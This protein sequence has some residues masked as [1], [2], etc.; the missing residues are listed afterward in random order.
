MISALRP[1]GHRKSADVLHCQP[2]RP[3]LPLQLGHG[4]LHRHL[5]LDWFHLDREREPKCKMGCLCVCMSL[6][7]RVFAV[8]KLTPACSRRSSTTLSTKSACELLAPQRCGT[9]LTRPSVVHWDT[10]S[11]PKSR[12]P[13]CV[14]R[15]LV[16]VFGPT[17]SVVCLPTSSFPICEW[18]SCPRSVWDV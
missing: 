16:S 17:R 1:S 12:L 3:S 2:F 6:F 8:G 18:P 5:T 10:S 13:N 14:Q 7:Q 9:F 15:R 4:R 11:L